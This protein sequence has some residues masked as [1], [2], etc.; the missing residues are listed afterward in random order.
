MSQVSLFYNDAQ[1]IVKLSSPNSSAKVIT[2]D[3]ES[4]VK[5][6]EFHTEN[7]FEPVPEPKK[8]EIIEQNFVIEEEELLINHEIEYETE[9]P[10]LHEIEQVEQVKKWIEPVDPDERLMTKLAHEEEIERQKDEYFETK[11]QKERIKCKP[12]K[13]VQKII[14]TPDPEPEPVRDKIFTVDEYKQHKKVVKYRIKLH[15]KIRELIYLYY[16]S[17]NDWLLDPELENPDYFEG[18]SKIFLII[19]REVVTED[20]MQKF[21]FL[22][23]V[24]DIFE[25][26]VNELRNLSN[27]EQLTKTKTR[28]SKQIW[29]IS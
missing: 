8:T 11:E 24:M 6:K 18:S 19:S 14:K 15:T 3:A 7:R 27:R 23:A 20:F 10:V 9:K 12:V 13:P 26:H 5:S 2:D 17:A 25:K 29:S 1:V 22:G 4:L 21:G 28:L 16:H